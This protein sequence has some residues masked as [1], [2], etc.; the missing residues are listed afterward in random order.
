MACFGLERV[1]RCRSSRGSGGR[2][3]LE[4]SC[5]RRLRRSRLRSAS[6]SLSSFRAVLLSVAELPPLPRLGSRLEAR[7]S[8]SRPESRKSSISNP[9]KPR[10]TLFL[11]FHPAPLVGGRNATYRNAVA[12]SMRYR[13][14]WQAEVGR[15]HPSQGEIRR[16]LP[17]IY[18][19]ALFSGKA[20]LAFF[21][22]LRFPILQRPRK[23]KKV[24]RIFGRR[25]SRSDSF[26]PFNRLF[27]IE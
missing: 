11:L 6:R 15:L 16:E 3:W 26:H 17:F 10:D 4:R 1:E 22:S 9:S 18:S 12:P 7:E 24:N 8:R 21:W 20:Q 27:S 25:G 13:T 19:E 14:G 23:R 5:D 2:V